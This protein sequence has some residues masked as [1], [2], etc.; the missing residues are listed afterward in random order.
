MPR[1]LERKERGPEPKEAVMM[2]NSPI[3]VAMSFV[4]FLILMGA[5]EYRHAKEVREEV[6]QWAKENNLT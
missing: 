5:I 6:R 4:M 3:L 1:H 2:D